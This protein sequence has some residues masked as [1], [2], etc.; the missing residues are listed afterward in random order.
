MTKLSL[1][2][3]KNDDNLEGLL[4]F[5]QIIEEMASRYTLDSYKAPVFNSHS[6][7]DEII[8]VSE[9]ISQGFL[10]ERGITP[11]KEELIWNLQN[12]PVAKHIL[13]YRYHSIIDELKAADNQKRLIAIVKPIQNLLEKKYFD[14]LKNTSLSRLKIQKIRRTFRFYQKSIFLNCSFTDILKSIYIK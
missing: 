12:D 4:F 9:E 13:D 11:I 8:D 3:W 6:L 2:N 1:E 5:A 14:E 10:H 7:C